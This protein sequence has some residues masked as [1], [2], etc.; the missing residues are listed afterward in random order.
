MMRA[1]TLTAAPLVFSL[2]PPA[3]AAPPRDR[4]PESLTGTVVSIADGDS[5]TIP[6]DLT[7]KF[8]RNRLVW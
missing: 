6:V 4:P 3:W 2:P 1:S 7:T 5:I 8:L